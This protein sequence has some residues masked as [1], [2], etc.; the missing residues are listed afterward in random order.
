MKMNRQTLWVMIMATMVTSAIMVAV[1]GIGPT[2]AQT[3]DNAS[4][5]MGNTTGG[6]MTG[7]NTTEMGGI[8][9]LCKGPCR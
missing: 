1:L 2:S 4:M 3:A 5:T 9:S 7:N 6:N 8:S